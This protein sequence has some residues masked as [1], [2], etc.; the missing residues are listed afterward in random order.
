MELKITQKNSKYT[1]THFLQLTNQ[2]YPTLTPHTPR[3]VHNAKDLEYTLI[4]LKHLSL[5]FP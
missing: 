2:N 1:Y 3:P 5:I 4:L